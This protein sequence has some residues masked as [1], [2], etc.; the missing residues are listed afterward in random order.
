M[1]SKKNTNAPIYQIETDQ[2]FKNKLMVTKGDRLGGGMV[3]VFGIGMCTLLYMEWMV[4]GDLVYSTEDSTQ[5]SLI[6]Y[7]RKESIKE[8]I[9]VYS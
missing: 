2:D 9:C 5:Y 4:N 3:W 7:T 1:E 6:T 8:W